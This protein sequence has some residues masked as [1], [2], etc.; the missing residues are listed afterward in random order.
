MRPVTSRLGT[1]PGDLLRQHRKALVAGALL[2][3]CTALFGI[4]LLGLS[5]WFITATA[6]AGLS[7]VAART[8]D[9]FAPSAGIRFLALGRTA[10]RYGERL[11]THDATLG[12]LAAVR[13]RLFRG[14][15]RGYAARRL[16]MRPARALF[17]LTMDIDALDS[18]YLRVIVPFLSALCAA[19]LSSVALGF[20]HP[21]YGVAVGAVLIATGIGVPLIASRFAMRPARRKANALET[22]R[23][24]VVDLVQGQTE[25]LMAGRAGAQCDAVLAADRR[26]SAADSAAHRVE[27]GVAAGHSLA[28][29][30]LLSGALV[31][32]AVLVERGT[33]GAPGAAFSL[34]V[35]F[36]A[37]EPFAPLRRGAIEIGRALLSLR[38]L[39]P[40]LGSEEPQPSKGMPPPPLAL[41]IEGAAAGY[42][43]GGHLVIKNIT[44]AVRR[45]ERVAIVGAS[46]S[47]KSTL[48]SLILGEL[49]PDMGKAVCLPA[50]LMTQRTELFQDTLRG[51]LQIADARA[52]D[53]SMHDALTSAGLRADLDAMPRGLDTRLGEGGMGLSGG[54][55]RR[56]SLA[57]LFLKDTSLWLLDEPTD[58]LDAPIAKE[59]MHRLVAECGDRTLIVATH[60]RC[61]A[62]IAD[63]I[64]SMREGRIVEDA[65]RKTAAFDRILSDLRAD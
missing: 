38:R 16:L 7:T 17:R 24:R 32:V 44:L 56:L 6:A 43:R 21:A 65:E 31:A 1:L 59:V 18:L 36:A 60:K 28:G 13:E 33:L 34:F 51:N 48:L 49:S 47:G 64:V 30:A 9:V 4:A 8:F 35:A 54:Q 50:T 53:A 52:D 2:S 29:A 20:I 63:R 58:G 46:G 40:H 12:I 19:I 15:A 22:L 10:A 42:E 23:S 26:L 55:S 61:E 25:L 57:R 62:E 5:G 11:V 37:L 14:C 27:T 45:G 39:A 3:A 41:D